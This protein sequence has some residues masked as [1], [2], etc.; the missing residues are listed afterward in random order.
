M[1]HGG[2]GE[3][4][5][6]R[7]P[8]PPRHQQGWHPTAPPAGGAPTTAGHEHVMGGQPQRQMA[9]MQPMQQQQQQ[10]PQGYAPSGPVSL[11]P[12]GPS[13][14]SAYRSLT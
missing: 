13:D 8:M 11:D 9:L 7:P 1:E 5:Y 3:F 4:N 14:V 2:A 6:A 12:E 10:Q